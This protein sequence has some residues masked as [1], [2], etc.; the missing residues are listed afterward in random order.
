MAT[1]WE[2]LEALFIKYPN[3][4]DFI[5]V[6]KKATV[7]Q[8]KIET[9]K[10]YHQIFYIS[11]QGWELTKLKKSDEVLNIKCTSN[12]QDVVTQIEKSKDKNYKKIIITCDNKT[13][14][15]ID[16]LKPYKD[17]IMIKYQSGNRVM[18]T[19]DEFITMRATIDYYK[20]I[21]LDQDLSPLE[22]VTYV[23][24]LI[25]SFQYE[26][27]S[28]DKFVTR[29]IHSIIKS[30]KIV[31]VGYAT[32]IAQILSELGLNCYLLSVE[33]KENHQGH[34]RLIIRI[35]DEK[36]NVDQPFAFDPTFD[37]AKNIVLCKDSSGN[38]CYRSNSSPTKEDDTPIKY[39]DNT[40]L[41]NYFLIPLTSYGAMFPD[42]VIKT[43]KQY[44]TNEENMTQEQ[45]EKLQSLNI[46]AQ[47]DII[48][49]IKLLYNVKIA[50]GYNSDNIV[51]CINDIL[52]INNLVT[53]DAQLLITSS[54]QDLDT[55]I[56][57]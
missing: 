25:K 15:D 22:Q 40:C 31:C 6:I 35:K 20:Q 47:K 1:K 34:E 51:E 24:D 48:M 45:K 2:E 13:F 37:S 21:V 57:Y 46:K 23:Y 29:S 7:D 55:T 44:L 9:V 38:L 56:K 11:K 8:E 53:G 33:K 18:C 5:N 12:M 17:N 52:N 32:F 43:S 28:N 19:L 14:D 30:G 27:N 50:E 54:I 4:D 42:E 10:T 3:L 26:E 49:F 41:Y 36:Y 39:Y 16:L